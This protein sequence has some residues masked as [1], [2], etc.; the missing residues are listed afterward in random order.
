MAG[1]LRELRESIETFVPAVAG[2]GV[3]ARGL[4]FKTGD[5]E[6]CGG[7]VARCK[8]SFNVYVPGKTCQSK[9]TISDAPAQL[10]FSH[11]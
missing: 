7:G 11:H 8:S 10:T 9:T 2:C 6:G 5:S 1:T 4:G 3:V